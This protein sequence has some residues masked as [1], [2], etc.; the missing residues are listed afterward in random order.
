MAAKKISQIAQDSGKT[1]V[2]T[3]GEG[4]KET[5]GTRYQEEE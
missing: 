2:Y 5:L 3:G 1:G 4:I